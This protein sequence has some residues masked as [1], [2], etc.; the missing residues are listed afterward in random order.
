VEEEV[1]REAMNVYGYFI[2]VVTAVLYIALLIAKLF[3]RRRR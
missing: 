1:E 2:S 3:R